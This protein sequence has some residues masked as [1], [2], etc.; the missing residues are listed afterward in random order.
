MKENTKIMLLVA[1]PIAVIGVS[2]LAYITLNKNN[3][4]NT[5]MGWARSAGNDVGSTVKW[6]G[7]G[8]GKAGN[9]VNQAIDWV[10]SGIGSA[11]NKLNNLLSQ[12][13]I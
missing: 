9:D 10:G 2:L 1:A 13:H 7:S 11:G 3:P 8:V 12:L 6:V 4:I 5:A